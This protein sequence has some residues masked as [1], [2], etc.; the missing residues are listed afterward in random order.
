MKK[1]LLVIIGIYLSMVGFAQNTYYWNGG[2]VSTSWS[3]GSNWNRT[4]GG[5]GLSRSTPNNGDTLIFD[6]S[7][8]GSGFTGQITVTNV[9]YQT[10]AAV[11]FRNGADIR[12]TTSPGTPLPS[13]TTAA[14][15]QNGTNGNF[16]GQTITGTGTSFSTFF[17]VGDF[18]NTGT[19]NTGTSATNSIGQITA[20][21][22]DVSLTQSNGTL[23][24]IATNGTSTFFMRTAMIRISNLLLVEAGSRFEMASSAPLVFKVNP[25]GVGTINGTIAV[26]TNFQKLVADA[27]GTTFITFNSG[28]KFQFTGS[29]STAP[30]D[31][32]A[33]ATNN[34]IIFKAG[35]IYENN[36]TTTATTN[37]CGSV[38]GAIIP[39]SVVEFQKGSTFVHN[40]NTVSSV[41]GN[42]HRAYP[43][44]ILANTTSGWQ[45]TSPVDTFTISSN[46]TWTN[47]SNSYFPIKGDLILNGNFASGTASPV[48]VFCGSVPQNISVNGTV[49]SSGF[50]RIVVG[51][52]ST[53]KITNSFTQ[54]LATALGTNG[55]Y[56]RNF[57]TLDF[58]NFVVSNAIQNQ[59][60]AL[61]GYSTSTT[62]GSQTGAV[63]AAATPYLIS[64]TSATGFSQGM[65]LTGTGIPANT[66][67]VL[68]SGTNITVSNPIP[69]GTYDIASSVKPNGSTFITANAGGIGANYPIQ[70]GS[71]YSLPSAPGANYFFNA[72]TTTPFPSGLSTVQVNNLTIAGS[73]TNNIRNLHVNGVLNLSNNMF[74]VL[75]TDTLR[76]N[77]G[78]A[79]AGVSTTNY[80]NLAVN[81]T[82]GDKAVLKIANI[83]APTLFPVGTNG[84][85][86]PVTITPSGTGEDYSVSVFDGVTDNALPNGT[87]ISAAQKARIVD[88]VW[89]IQNNVSLTGNSSL[90][91][92]WPAALEGSS[93]SAFS[94]SQIGIAQNIVNSGWGNFTGSGN[95]TTNTATN[96]FSSFSAF[97]VGEVGISLPAKFGTI[98]L[99]AQNNNTAKITW[100]VF[101]EISTNY[102][103]IEQSS[104]GYSFKEVGSEKAAGATEYSVGNISILNGVNYFRIKAVDKNGTSLYSNIVKLMNNKNEINYSIYPNPTRGNTITLNIAN[105][106]TEKYFVQVIDI[107]GKVVY[108]NTVNHAAGSANYTLTLS[109]IIHSGVYM[110]N[111]VNSKGEVASSKLIIQ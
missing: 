10:V 101:A 44:V 33:N 80:I 23:S 78:N 81:K 109:N 31:G 84:Y 103:V 89:N 73:V 70:T 43:N 75:A 83:N 37:S 2:G 96:S 95:N 46:T 22:S 24:M 106:L 20:I 47:T 40:S 110:F 86:L 14:G 1:T 67:I 68:I 6:G 35:S 27:N 9:P 65:L 97:T 82:T 11:I 49:V 8:L 72:S 16:T 5:G 108:S 51:A 4:L 79:I 56:I 107:A 39:F 98:H 7:N 85:Y 15:V 59:S 30:F 99:T 53:L 63:V 60:G 38:F 55:S 76:I 13:G 58:G 3:T 102:Y 77:S 94:N 48:F 105:Q 74:N 26:T 64:V 34:N 18:V 42:A 88:A 29:Q 19:T 104:N 91:L 52:G 32:L 100:Q 90:Q 28:S 41:I 66:T 87:A 17:T 93:F 25:G 61:Q 62:T 57:G 92:G 50:A 12:F 69:A 36:S 54:N 21:N 71:T 45:P 111:L